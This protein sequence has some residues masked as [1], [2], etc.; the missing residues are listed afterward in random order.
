M[1]LHSTPDSFDVSSAENERESSIPHERQQHVLSEPEINA[2]LEAQESPH[3][4]FKRVSGKMVSKAL[5]TLCAFANSH[6]GTLILGIADPSL[7]SG[8]DRIFGIEENPEAVDE[9]RR[10]IET[11]FDPPGIPVRYRFVAVTTP[12]HLR[13]NL[14]MLQVD[15]SDHV[16]SIVGD[17][18]WTRLGASNAQM[19]ARQ[20]SE[21]AYKR[22]DRSAESECMGV[23]C[24]L[25]DTLT[26]RTYASARGLMSG[27][28]KDQ[29]VRVG[30]GESHG[31]VVHPRRA[32]VLLFSDEPGG[33]LAAVGRDANCA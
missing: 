23:D 28:I 26:W 6:G 22:G 30:L 17:G 24:A 25:L 21:L 16:H 15:R 20:I 11:Q 19:T 1:L 18:T 4:E 7:G 3:L 5:E 2:I 31:G 9:L 8:A 27:G 10:K 13:L 12:R 14:M 32:A 33:H 29:L